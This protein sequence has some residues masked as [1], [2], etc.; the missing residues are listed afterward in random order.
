MKRMI[1]KSDFGQDL[2]PWC[3]FLCITIPRTQKAPRKMSAVEGKGMGER[4]VRGPW[5]TS[6]HRT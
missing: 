2:E 5:L 4:A 6:D 3:N 1:S